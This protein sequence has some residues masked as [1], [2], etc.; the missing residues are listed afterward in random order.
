MA[1]PW[2]PACRRP[3]ASLPSMLKG[4]VARLSSPARGPAQLPQNRLPSLTALSPPMPMPARRL[5]L[6]M[7]CG[8]AVQ[9]YMDPQGLG[10]TE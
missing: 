5:V 4:A 8:S 3:S 9:Q 6:I 1:A 7:H 2:R 10:Q